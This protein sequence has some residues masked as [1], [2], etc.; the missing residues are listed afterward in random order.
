MAHSVSTLKPSV[1]NVCTKTD[2]TF[3]VV[4]GIHSLLSNML[5]LGTLSRL[6]IAIKPIRQKQ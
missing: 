3:I 1:Y 6:L 4:I 2:W 5:R